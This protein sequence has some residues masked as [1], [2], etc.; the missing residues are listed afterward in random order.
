MSPAE[1]EKQIQ[2]ISAE[3]R[4]HNYNYYVL[5]MP[6]I[7]D[8]DFDKKL[9]QLIALEKQFPEFADPD[10]P[11]QKVGGFITKEF[12]TVK[13][14]WPMLSLGNTY[15]EQELLDFDQRVRKAIGDNFE[16]VCELKFDGL[17]M[18]LTYENGLL[19]LAVTRGDGVEGREGTTNLRNIKT[20][21]KRLHENGYPEH[22]E[23]RG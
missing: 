5:A 23:I 11:S 8:F 2:N 14:K 20:L 13:H 1:A 17:S 21:P 10:S 18:S 22:F 19:A 7:S 15:N 4:Q 3:L 16:Y 12:K 9:E 6:A